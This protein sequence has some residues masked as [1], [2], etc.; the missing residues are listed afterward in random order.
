MQGCHELLARSVDILNQN[1]FLQD[2]L[3]VGL[4]D[5]EIVKM[6]S[7]MQQDLL[8]L[9]DF[10]PFS[11]KASSGLVMERSGDLSTPLIM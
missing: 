4:Y 8:E 1:L 9:E 6:F 11:Q 5:W 10:P 3:K 7:Y 2:I